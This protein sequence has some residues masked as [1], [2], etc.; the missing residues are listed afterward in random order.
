MSE[1][2]RYDAMCT[3]IAAAIE[4]DEV[5]DIRDRAM[6]LA[7]YARQAQ[8]REAERRAMEIRVRA[9]RRAGELFRGDPEGKGWQS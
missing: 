5:K 6:A 4:V 9:E 1:L 3:A 2:V 7:C 8:N